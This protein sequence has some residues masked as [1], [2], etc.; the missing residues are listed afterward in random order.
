MMAIEEGVEQGNKVG[1]H[2]A[3]R[4]QTQITPTQIALTNN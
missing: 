1:E 3:K 4:L 2:I